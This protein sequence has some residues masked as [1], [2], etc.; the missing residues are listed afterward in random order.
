MEK[1]TKSSF[2]WDV[3][4]IGDRTGIEYPS[5]ESLTKDQRFGNKILMFLTIFCMMLFIWTISIW[6]EGGFDWNG[7]GIILIW[8]FILCIR[9]FLLIKQRKTLNTIEQLKMCW[10]VIETSI[11]YAKLAEIPDRS[12]KQFKSYTIIA[13]KWEISYAASWVLS[14]SIDIKD[15]DNVQIFMDPQDP[16]IYYMDLEHFYS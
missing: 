5:T 6:F 9:I 1:R 10:K 15:W 4:I 3:D 7:A 16:T 13:K 8:L 12:G 14:R 2:F 11:V